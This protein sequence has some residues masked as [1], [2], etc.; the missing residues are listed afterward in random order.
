[1]NKTKKLRLRREAREQSR[2]TKNNEE[3]DYEV[4]V[5]PWTAKLML[6]RGWDP[7][8][9]ETLVRQG[10]FDEDSSSGDDGNSS[11]GGD[12]EK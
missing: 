8:L 11:E 3:I 10:F 7:E 6:E 1:M 4:V 2:A 5:K 12:G 9:V